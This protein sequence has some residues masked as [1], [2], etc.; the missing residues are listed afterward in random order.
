[1]RCVRGLSPNLPTMFQAMPDSP[2]SEAMFSGPRMASSTK[3]PVKSSAS[4]VSSTASAAS[5]MGLA[6]KTCMSDR[7]RGKSGGRNS[8]MPPRGR[9]AQ[10]AGGVYM[11]RRRRTP[12]SASQR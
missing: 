4:M 10:P 6:G 3:P 11:K 7:L 8:D 2:W 9:P 12:G 1:M 5:L